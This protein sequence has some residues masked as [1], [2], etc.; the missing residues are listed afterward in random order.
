MW[1]PFISEALLLSRT[2]DAPCNP[3][4]TRD[5]RPATRHLTRDATHTPV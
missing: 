3:P 2:H 5:P 1:V 4:S